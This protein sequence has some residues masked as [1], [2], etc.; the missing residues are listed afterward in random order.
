MNVSYSNNVTNT[1]KNLRENVYGKEEFKSS[2]SKNLENAISAENIS[3]I[4]DQFG[5]WSVNVTTNTEDTE[6]SA[7]VMKVT[8]AL[9]DTIHSIDHA[10]STKDIAC[11][12][13]NVIVAGHDNI[14][15]K[16]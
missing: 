11:N 5:G 1:V 6:S 14:I 8:E 10:I 12:L 16:L 13:A 4:P 2:F 9:V 3:F 15:V 7:Y